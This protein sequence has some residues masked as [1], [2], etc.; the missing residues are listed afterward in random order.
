MCVKPY[1]IEHSGAPIYSCDID[2]LHQRL[3]TSGADHTLCVW[4]LPPLL[5]LSAEMSPAPRL[6][7]T[8]SNHNNPVNCVR[9]SPLGRL[10]A[11]CS[12][13]PSP[14]ILL[15]RLHDPDDPAYTSSKPF[16]SPQDSDDVDHWALHAQL[17]GHTADVQDLAFSPCGRFL[18]SASVDNDVVVWD[19]RTCEAKRKLRGHRG[20]VRGVSWDPRGRYVASLG[21]DGV[22][23][24]WDSQDDWKVKRAITESLVGGEGGGGEGGGVGGGGRKVVGR[25]GLNEKMKQV[26]FSRLSWIA[27]GSAIGASK[28]FD[29]QGKVSVSP[30]FSRGSWTRWC[31]F[32]GHNHP[33]TVTKFNPKMFTRQ[34][35]HNTLPHSAAASPSSSS[36]SFNSSSTSTPAAN[37]STSA[38]RRRSARNHI[39]TLSL[40]KSESLP[41]FYPIHTV[42]AVGS[43]DNSVSIWITSSADVLAR[44]DLFFTQTVTDLSWSSDGYNLLA[45]SHDGT[46]AFFRFTEDDFGRSL[47]DE[48]MKTHMRREYGEEGASAVEVVTDAVDGVLGMELEEMG[49]EY[50]ERVRNAREEDGGDVGSAVVSRSVSVSAKLTSAEVMAKQKEAQKVDAKGRV[51]RVVT[52]LHVEGGTL[53]SSSAPAPVV[54]VDLP[55]VPAFIASSTLSPAE[56][57]TE[58]QS[59]A[60]QTA[61]S[62]YAEGSASKRK[63]DHDAS[64]SVSHKKKKHSTVPAG[65]GGL[66]YPAPPSSVDVRDASVAAAASGSAA[67]SAN[68]AVAVVRRRVIAPAPMR[69]QLLCKL[70]PSSTWQQLASSSSW[71]A[72]PS[73]DGVVES[74]PPQPPFRPSSSTSGSRPRTF[75]SLVCRRSGAEQWQTLLPGHCTLLACTPDILAAA[76]RDHAEEDS[77]GA[78]HLLSHSGRRLLPPI[79]LP[80]PPSHLS[81]SSPSP[82]SLQSPYLLVLTSS[83]RLLVLS[84]SPYQC[85]L[86]LSVASLLSGSSFAGARVLDDG[87]VVLMTADGNCWMRDEG[88]GV[89]MDVGDADWV[90]ST[91][92]SR[93]AAWSAAERVDDADSSRSLHALQREVKQAIASTAPTPPLSLDARTRTLHT[94]AHLEVGRAARHL[95]CA[96]SLIHPP[97]PS[98]SLYRSLLCFSRRWW[99]LSTSAPGSSISAGCRLTCRVRT[100]HCMR[101]CL[102]YHLTVDR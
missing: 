102:S 44:F 26:H 23:I 12:D 36:P 90:G 62:H 77:G 48:E 22:L 9:F 88:M 58:P 89:W 29:G 19:V 94:I 91:F 73:S 96:G 53:F 15:W 80:S 13:G 31:A 67:G 81:F 49:K 35:L 14:S 28:G 76:C 52:P 68:T 11:S 25:I 92:Q 17:I 57:N 101:R 5:S 4:A 69:R 60:A 87:R 27:D 82:S 72:P 86:D 18:A 37:G 8:L 71:P 20:W 38:S 41:P 66:G 24:V 3:A 40:D 34:P 1:W 85:K 63:R 75:T 74:F 98:S 50:G 59:R 45:S 39:S 61:A 56:P 16:G 83:A 2:P 84:T 10:L 54:V 93:L 46:V 65:D 55:P 95:P 64:G 79:H 33:T 43:L 6:L 51:R 32:V 42:C 21:E 47:T 97:H 7:A 100:P 30:V 70:L 78:L 99:L